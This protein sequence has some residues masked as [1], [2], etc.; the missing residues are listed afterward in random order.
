MG[1]GDL[2]ITTNNDVTFP[3]GTYYFH[4]FTKTGNGA[5]HVAAGDS[6]DIYISGA[7]DLQ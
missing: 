2:S 7:L 6:V 3:G 1:T 5:L 4:N